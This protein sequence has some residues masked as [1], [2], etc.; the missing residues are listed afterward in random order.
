MKPGREKAPPREREKGLMPRADR[1][2]RTCSLA[3]LV[4]LTRPSFSTAR[5]QIPLHG[6]SHLRQTLNPGV[7]V[8]PDPSASLDTDW[9][10]ACVL[11]GRLAYRGSRHCIAKNSANSA[12]NR[13]VKRGF[14]ACQEKSTRLIQNLSNLYIFL[15][16]TAVTMLCIRRG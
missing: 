12:S 11:R 5:R 16:P 6:I 3:E 9:A 13:K 2:A 15:I 8:L 4:V 1:R 14:Q 10:V 7:P